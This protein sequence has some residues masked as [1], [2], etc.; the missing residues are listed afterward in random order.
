MLLIDLSHTSHTRAQ[1]GIQRV[2]RSLHTAI[3]AVH[4]AQAITYD[5][6]RQ[7][8]RP[9]D[10]AEAQNLSSTAASSTRGAQWPLSSRVR[11]RLGH[12]LGLKKPELPAAQGL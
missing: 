11:G 5:P 9:L 4:D 7:A 12:L 6:Y 1:T 2:C 3:S 10:R 8:W